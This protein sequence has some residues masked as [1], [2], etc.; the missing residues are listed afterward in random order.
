MTGSV[1]GD[2]PR[3][4][5]RQ[6]RLGCVEGAAAIAS[7]IPHAATISSSILKPHDP[8][9]HLNVGHLP[10]AAAA[11]ATARDSVPSWPTCARTPPAAT[12]GSTARGDGFTS[13]R[14][15]GVKAFITRPQ[16]RP[17]PGSC[18][19]TLSHT[20]VASSHTV[21]LHTLPQHFTFHHPLT[22]AVVA[23]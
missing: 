6:M 1:S 10:A 9:A 21:T 18:T 8:N 11:A 14:Q 12:P 19:H 20:C 15:V 4:R 5:G 7:G 23:L 16:P 17:R 22:E 3:E 2:R 13:G